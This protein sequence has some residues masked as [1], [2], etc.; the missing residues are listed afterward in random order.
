MGLGDDEYQLI[1]YQ[2]SPANVYRTNQLQEIF[3]L[4]HTNTQW[5]GV[6]YAVSNYAGTGRRHLVSAT[7]S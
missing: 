6:G 7:W 2:D 4:V 3:V 5:M 1:N